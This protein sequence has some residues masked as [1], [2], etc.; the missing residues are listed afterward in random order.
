MWIHYRLGLMILNCIR[1]LGNH[2][3]KVKLWVVNRIKHK[4]VSE[5]R[6]FIID[7]FE[8]FHKSIETGSSEIDYAELFGD[9][10]IDEKDRADFYA[11]NA[12]SIPL[13]YMVFKEE[14]SLAFV[15]TF[16]HNMNAEFHHRLDD[17]P[18]GFK[19]YDLVSYL[20]GDTHVLVFGLDLIDF[21][22]N[23]IFGTGG[24]KNDL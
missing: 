20:D 2:V 6:K 11:C 3:P 5:T 1:F 19:L 8:S 22:Q 23:E 10:E 14:T 21:H 13:G 16:L 18:W 4:Q 9:E 15:K 17:L 24:T 7:Y 12:S